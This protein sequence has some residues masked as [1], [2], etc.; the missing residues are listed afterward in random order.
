MTSLSW[1]MLATLPFGF[2]VLTHHKGFPTLAP[3]HSGTEAPPPIRSLST[4]ATGLAWSGK[5]DDEVSHRPRTAP[6]EWTRPSQSLQHLCLCT[7]SPCGHPR[8]WTRLI[9]FFLIIGGSRGYNRGFPK[10]FRSLTCVF[11][12][13]QAAG[14]QAVWSSC[15]RRYRIT[16]ARFCPPAPRR[17]M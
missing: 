6:L 8:E 14:N 15:V 10:R 1:A 4:D 5:S 16:S 13:C 9:D 3:G 2:P 17:P 7:R 12:F 11:D